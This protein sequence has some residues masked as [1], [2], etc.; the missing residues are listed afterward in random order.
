MIYDEKG[1][2]EKYEF[3]S[4]ILNPKFDGEEFNPANKKY[5]F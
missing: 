3:S 2:Y 1:L 5:K 4:F